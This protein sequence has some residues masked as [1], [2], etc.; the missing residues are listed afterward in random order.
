MIKTRLRYCVFD[1]DRRGNPRYY[2]RKPGSKKIR[3]REAFEDREGNIRPEFMKAYFAA[4][5]SLSGIPRPLQPPPREKTFDWL[6]DQ[7]YKSSRFKGFDPATQADKRS[8]LNRFC[9]TAGN[10]PYALFRTKDVEASQDKRR[11]TPAAADKLV[12]YLRALF[13]WAIKS[14]HAKSNPAVGV[15]KIH[16]TVGWHTWSLAEI[17]VYRQ[18]HEVGTKARLALEI[19]LNV[20]ARISDVARIGRQH[21]VDG[22]LRFVAW[23]GRGKKKTRRTIDIP[24]SADLAVSVAATSTGDLT[25]LVAES[26]QPFTINGLGN[27]MRDWCD[28]AGL[29]HCSAHGLRK[30]SAV[31]MAESGVT[32]PELCAV[33]GW[34]KLETAE[35]YI[36]EANATRMSANAFARLEEY[37]NRKSISPSVTKTKSETIRKKNRD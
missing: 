1:P 14:G 28:A 27:K 29:H 2:V 33:F 7:Y 5:E 9:E 24:I 31:A 25:Y 15:E 32:A 10:L 20:G 23:K 36:R 8:V 26:G 3:I 12:K 16:E 34:G 37:R 4:L 35:I 21:E 11:A 22:R 18:H 6:V 30:A 19:F 13:A 17:A